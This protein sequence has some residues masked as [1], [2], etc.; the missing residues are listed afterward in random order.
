MSKLLEQAIVDAEAL[1]EAALKSAESTILEKYSAEVK[2][3]IETILEQE[4]GGMP[5]P[6]M[7]AA[8]PLDVAP[9]AMDPEMGGGETAEG[10][11]P[12]MPRADTDGDSLCP[13]PDEEEEIEIDFNELAA[14]LEDEM[15][16]RD[17]LVQDQVDMAQAEPVPAVGPPPMELSEGLDEEFDISDDLIDSIIEK[18]EF[19]VQTV[20][21]G[22]AGGTTNPVIEKEVSD[23]EIARHALEEDDD[24]TQELQEKINALTYYGGKLFEEN[25]KYRT[26]MYKLKEKLEE[27]NLSNARLFYTNK[28]LGSTSL[29]E[30]QKDKI[31]EALS[32]TSTVEEAKIVFETLQSA[33][34]DRNKRRPKSLSEVVSRPST[35][36]PRP[37]KTHKDPVNNRW[38]TLAGIK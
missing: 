29:N 9:V 14:E 5:G 3:A 30:R 11:F 36:L 16:D 8:P 19:D 23:I 35:T 13:C 10:E 12:D 25:K 33:V 18:L 26:I 34:G 32:R 24:E 38:K 22:Q 2:N 4:E 7:G 27:T 15:T 1:K 6:P 20:P 21:T 31:V 28:V 37:R 17:E